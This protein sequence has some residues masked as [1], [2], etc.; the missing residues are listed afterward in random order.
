MAYG[1]V[2]PGADCPVRA[3]VSLSY[4]LFEGGSSG[5]HKALSPKRCGLWGL[6]RGVPPWMGPASDLAVPLR[7]A[8]NEVLVVLHL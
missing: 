3:P 8:G 6:V 4:G 2:T 5:Q 1:G 7:L